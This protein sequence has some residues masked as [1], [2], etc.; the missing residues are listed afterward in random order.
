MSLEIIALML[1]AACLH[2]SWNAV[3]KGGSDKLYETG[4]NTLGGGI[5]II[6]AL[7]FLPLPDPASWPLLFIS[8][9][10]HVAYYLCMAAAYRQSEMSYAY[11]LMRGTTPLFTALAMLGFGY[12]VSPMG[13]LGILCLCAGV[14]TLASQNLLNRSFNGRGTAAALGNAV[15]IMGY[16]LADGF[17]VRASGHALSYVC[18]LYFF[19]MFPLNALILT[20]RGNDYVRY[21]AQRWKIGLFGGLCS[22]GAY[23]VALWAMTRAPIALVAA[24]RETS[25]VF[26]MLLAVLFLGERFTRVR[27]LAVLLVAA[28]TAIMRLS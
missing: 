24:L 10:I 19:N 23:G 9:F 26:G 28:G 5:G 3:I 7:P 16:T 22:L 12:A 13:W 8:M 21:I 6:F 20:R 15:V 17:G 14:L 4:I 1:F 18:W 2:A 27:L 25:V 11:T